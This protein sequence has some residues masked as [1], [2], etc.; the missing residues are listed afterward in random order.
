M[1]LLLLLIAT[2]SPVCGMFC[3]VACFS[4]NRS[5]VKNA[6][7]F[8]YAC[9]W[10][11][12]GYISDIGQDIIRHMQNLNAYENVSLL[13]C[14]DAGRLS[15]TYT[16]DIWSWFVAHLNNPHLLQSTGVCRIYNIIIYNLRLFK[17]K[18]NAAKR[19]YPYIFDCV[20]N[21]IAFGYFCWD[22]VRKCVLCLHVRNI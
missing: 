5:S 16:W 13:H 3:S 19:I 9:G 21:G 7:I 8:G 14:F 18:T 15:V 22:K 2:F 20:N 4:R 12:Y 1:T 17:Q 10:G 11:C 6:L